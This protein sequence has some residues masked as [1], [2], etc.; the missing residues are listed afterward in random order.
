MIVT[1]IPQTAPNVLTV[2]TPIA[3]LDISE[4]SGTQLND[5]EYLAAH[6]VR[7]RPGIITETP[8]KTAE[9]T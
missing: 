5:C 2:L 8:R 4:H 7:H 9:R 6:L 3:I 1:A